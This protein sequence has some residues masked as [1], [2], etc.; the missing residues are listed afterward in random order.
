VRSVPSLAWAYCLLMLSS[1][2]NVHELTLLENQTL[3][4][5]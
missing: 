5:G 1:W 4:L 2:D 3:L